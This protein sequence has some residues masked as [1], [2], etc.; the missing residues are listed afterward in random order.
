MPVRDG[1]RCEQI[2]TVGLSHSEDAREAQRALVQKRKPL[3]K[4]R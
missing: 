1:Y 3:L 4:R 2:V